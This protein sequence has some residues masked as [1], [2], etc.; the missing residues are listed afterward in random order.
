MNENETPPI[1]ILDAAD[2]VACWMKQNGVEAV[3]AVALRKE[4]RMT[5][6]EV[7]AR[8]Q[9][10]FRVPADSEIAMERLVDRF[11]SWTLPSSVCSDQ[12]ACEY[13]RS[14][15]SGTNLLNAE[16]TRLMI[17]HLFA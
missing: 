9:A 3:G 7:F 4:D 5:A 10:A 13:G 15:R 2:K 12:C 17:R 14:D 1:H 6:S 8:Q 16:E 11:L